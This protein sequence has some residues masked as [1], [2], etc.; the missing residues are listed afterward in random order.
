M[1]VH[2][3]LDA[4]RH[5]PDQDE[6]ELVRVAFRTPALSGLGLAVL[7]PV[8]RPRPSM[9]GAV[10]AGPRSLDNG[11]VALTVGRDGT[12][13][14]ADRRTGLL[15][16]ALLGFESLGDVGD[17]LPASRPAAATGSAAGAVPSTC[18]C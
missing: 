9:E 1:S 5:Y 4:P 13:T 17:T 8:D 12:V 16:P 7:E 14:L 15:Y 2:E 3:R 10:R 11:L 18:G 6:V